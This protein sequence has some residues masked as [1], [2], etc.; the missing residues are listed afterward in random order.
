MRV[1]VLLL[2]V[3][4]VSSCSTYNEDQLNGFDKEIKEYLQKNNIDCESSDSG[5]HYK[6]LSKGEGQPVQVKDRISFSY[7]GSLLNGTVF[8]KQEEPVSFQVSE[9]IGAWKEIVLKLN[10]GGEAYLVAPPQLGY[11]AR[12]LDDIPAN[13]I[14]VFTLKVHEVE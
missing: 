8:D 2:A 13:S 3:L 11:G 7:T 1:L 10:E 12:E 6:I 9:L 5:L 4:T 14:L